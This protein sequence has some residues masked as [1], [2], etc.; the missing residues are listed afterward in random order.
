[1]VTSHAFRSVAHHCTLCCLNKAVTSR[2]KSKIMKTDK[3]SLKLFDMMS[4]SLDCVFCFGVSIRLPFPLVCIH[5]A[6]SLD[7]CVL[8]E[9]L[10]LGTSGPGLISG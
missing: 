6:L 7:L 4:Y 10:W 2:K 3:N 8:F 9:F 5:L 1:M